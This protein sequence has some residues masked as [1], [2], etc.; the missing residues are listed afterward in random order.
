MK[1]KLDT[2]FEL[3]PRTADTEHS[4]HCERIPIAVFESLEQD[5]RPIMRRR[6][7]RAIYRGPRKHNHTIY[8]PSM[9][10]RCDATH[11]LIYFG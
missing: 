9:T 8:R 5:L 4:A 11:V 3:F 10:R 7:L 2:L 1:T 6:G